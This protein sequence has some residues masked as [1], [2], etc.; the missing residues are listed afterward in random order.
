MRYEEL[1]PNCEYPID[2]EGLSIGDEV[3]CDNCKSEYEIY[4][5]TDAGYGPE[6][7]LKLI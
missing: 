1:C 5:I 2:C 3:Q 6:Y 7:T 4:S